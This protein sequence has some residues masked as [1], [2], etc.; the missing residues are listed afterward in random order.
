MV[1]LA[2]EI[3]Q[4]PCDLNQ[5]VTLREAADRLEELEKK[6]DELMRAVEREEILRTRFL[7]ERDAA[8]FELCA[9]VAEDRMKDHVAQA[10]K[11][12]AREYGWDYLCD[13]PP[14]KDHP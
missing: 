14:F 13:R 8:R 1:N 9:F 4:L 3:R 7:E 2:N 6:V 12:I 5:V 10:W 11:D